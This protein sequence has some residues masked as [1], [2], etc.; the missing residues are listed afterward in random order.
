MHELVVGVD[1]G[2][3][4]T[5]AAL[6]RGESVLRT[7]AGEGANLATR[8]VE[9][10]AETIARCIELVLEGER[11]AAIG[12]GAA[13]AGDE[14]RRERLHHRLSSRFPGARIA[15]AHDARMA[16]RAVVPN[17]DAMVVVAGTGSIAYAEVG[18]QSYR[19][20]GHG[21]LFGD[22][23]S[24]FAIGVTA[25]RRLLAALESD[26]V[27]SPMLAELAANVGRTRSAVLARFYQSATPVSEIAGCAPAV[28]AHAQTGD[29]IAG[30]IVNE[31]ADGL[32]EMIRTLVKV[33]DRHALPLA[34]AGG[35]LRERNALTTGLEARVAQGSLDIRVVKTRRE[36]YFG[37]LAEARRLIES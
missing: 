22:A 10:A 15:L 21:Y 3:S 9:G 2:A 14:G 25:L 19:A 24:G 36:P 23:G 28:L 26:D 7:I 1:A 8:G 11:A 16:L 30:A 33:C 17:G 35:L 12:I 27:S 37:A 29:E 5:V 34:F 31:A 20:G 13:G 32:Y 18:E 6:A 4:H